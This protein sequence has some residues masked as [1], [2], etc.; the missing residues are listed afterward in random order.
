MSESEIES[1]PWK[2]L[3]ANTHSVEI[4]YITK[5]KELLTRVYFPFESSVSVMLVL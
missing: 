2:L 3:V 1:E 5:E 4:N